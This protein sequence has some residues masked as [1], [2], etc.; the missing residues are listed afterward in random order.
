MI[1]LNDHDHDDGGGGGG[2]SG[3][4]NGVY[5]NKTFNGNKFGCTSLCSNR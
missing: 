2:G 3:S 1:K 5:K 4:V